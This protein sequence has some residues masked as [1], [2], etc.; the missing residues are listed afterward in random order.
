MEVIGQVYASAAF[1]RVKIPRNPLDRRLNGPRRRSGRC[2]EEKNI[3]SLHSPGIEPGYGAH[4]LVAI[5]TELPPTLY[6]TCQR[7]IY[8][9]TGLKI[10]ESLHVG[11]L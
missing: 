4:S 7:R 5:L 8:K 6:T 11:F 9:V 1:P 3:P 2:G 10:T